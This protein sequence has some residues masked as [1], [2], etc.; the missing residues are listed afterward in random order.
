MEDIIKSVIYSLDR[1]YILGER[2][3][4]YYLSRCTVNTVFIPLL[5]DSEFLHARNYVFFIFIS[6]VP[7]MYFCSYPGGTSGEEPACQCR[8]HNRYGF[9]PQIGKIPCRRA[10]QPT[11]VFLPG[12]SHKQRRLAGYSPQGCRESNMNE[13]SQH[14]HTHKYKWVNK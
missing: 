6:S 7:S 5:L 11:P 13:A 1:F 14:T 10:R 12:E 9:D 2:I 4:Y 8:R 3:L